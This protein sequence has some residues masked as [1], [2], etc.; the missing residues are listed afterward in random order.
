VRRQSEAATA[1]WIVLLFLPSIG[2]NAQASL[3]KMNPSLLT[4]PKRRRR[5]ALAGALQINY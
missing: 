5:F 4:K 2:S 3:K 1:L